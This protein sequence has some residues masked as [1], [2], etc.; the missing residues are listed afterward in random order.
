M[1]IVSYYIIL[2]PS[3]DVIAVYP[4][5]NHVI[6]NNL[7]IFITGHDTSVKPK[8]RCDWIL[9]IALKVINA[10][11]P[12]V[13]AFGVANLVYILK[14]VGVFGFMC[15]AFPVLLQMKST[16]VCKKTFFTPAVKV[17]VSPTVGKSDKS[18]VD[19]NASRN[20]DYGGKEADK[21]MSSVC[22]AAGRKYRSLLSELKGFFLPNNDQSKELRHFYMTPYS[23]VVFSHPAF[24][25]VIG[26]IGVCV[27]ILAVLGLFLHPSIL[28]CNILLDD[29]LQ[30]EL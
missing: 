19:E 30:E 10:L 27:F 1:R 9:R 8:Y 28:S 2:F 18:T 26:I 24:V 16:Y 11:L 7:Y 22:N 20:S 5:S 6:T 4:L 25:L 21:T 29:Y 12:I 17:P 23:H 14:F 15:Y 3:L 13:A